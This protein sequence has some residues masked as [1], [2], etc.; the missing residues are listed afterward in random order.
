MT[1]LFFAIIAGGVYLKFTPEFEQDKPTISLD[2][3]IFWNLKSKIKLKIEDASGIKYYK[4]VFHNGTQDI[5]LDT[6]VLSTPQKVLN[7]E[8]K[9]YGLGTVTTN[10]LAAPPIS[11]LSKEELGVDV[12]LGITNNLTADFTYNTDFAQVEVDDW[13]CV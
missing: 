3:N 5:V 13:I 9:P 11:N 6:K 4:I 7:L 2:D 12:K 10:R 8:I 1:I